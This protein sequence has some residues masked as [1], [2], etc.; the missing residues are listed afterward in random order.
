MVTHKSTASCRALS[1]VD[2]AVDPTVD[3]IFVA[4][5]ILLLFIFFLRY[6]VLFFV[7]VLCFFS[8]LFLCPFDYLP[9]TFNRQQW[10]WILSN[11]WQESPLPIT[12]YDYLLF[13]FLSCFVC[14]VFPFLLIQS[15]L[16]PRDS[17]GFWLKT[18]FRGLV[19]P[20]RKE[21]EVHFDCTNS[22]LI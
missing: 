13:F 22:Q 14:F 6:R 19:D 2:A 18:S 17:Y 16:S 11:G 12:S 3:A 20:L 1:V 9:H 5:L 10:F 21:R 8:F 15:S 4:I 7:F